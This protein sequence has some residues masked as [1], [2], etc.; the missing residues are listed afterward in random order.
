MSIGGSDPDGGAGI[1]ADLK[2]FTSL[3]VYGITVITCV[4]AQNTFRYLLTYEVPPS[5]V[6]AQI[7][8]IFEDFQVDAAKTGML[9]SSEVIEV[10]R[11]K[12]VGR[13]RLV[14]DPVLR[15][16]TGGELL[17][18]EAVEALMELI[19]EADI[20]TPNIDEARVLTGM[21]IEKVEDMIKAGELLLDLGAKA[22]VVKGGHL[23]NSR[24]V[25]DIYLDHD[26][27]IVHHKPRI[28][29]QDLHG[30]GCS[31]S[32]AITAYLAK[33]L[34]SSE[35]FI[36]AENFILYCIKGALRL[37]RG[38]GP[39]NQFYIV[40]QA[41]ERHEI[42][43]K[44]MRAIS[45]MRRY[46]HLFAKFIPEV[47]MN[48]VMALRRAEGLGEVCGIAGRIRRLGD[49]VIIGRVRFGASNHLARAVLT[50]MK[51]YPE[52]RSCLNLKY[53]DKILRA[54]KELN[55]A[56]ASF[57]RR[58]E[59]PHVKEKEGMTIPWG[60]SEAVRGLGKAPD[61]I[62][63]LGDVGKEPMIRIFGRD[64]VEVIQKA[65]LL[66]AKAEAL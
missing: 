58:R 23:I 66:M 43:R 1:Q 5:V 48:L 10:I 39:V 24:D 25:T 37:G 63:D 34:T 16:K 11:R 44:M 14:V 52:M 47:G 7:D 22:V 49:R 27:L 17:R 28:A 3:G 19:T 64:A 42:K 31:F 40:Q 2:T 4:T 29:T 33:G 54:A 13:T 59:P 60:I 53:D 18:K 55:L 15:S 30:V 56:I 46:Q 21:R 57:D 62:Y 35:A 50:M 20:V 51:Y 41:L 6:E 36:K 65:I 26:K 38:S 45:L 61:L 32:A 9:Y 8:A 12:V